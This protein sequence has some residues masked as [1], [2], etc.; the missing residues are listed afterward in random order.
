[1]ERCRC[2]GECAVAARAQAAPVPGPSLRWSARPPWGN[3]LRS[4]GDCFHGS[5]PDVSTAGPLPSVRDARKRYNDLAHKNITIDDPAFA[6]GF[7]A[8]GPVA[9]TALPEGVRS[10][11]I[12]RRMLAPDARVFLRI[13]DPELMQRWLKLARAGVG[14]PADL[15]WRAD[16]DPRHKPR[17]D[18]VPSTHEWGAGALTYLE[19][20]RVS[21]DL[22]GGGQLIIEAKAGTRVHCRKSTDRPYSPR[23]TEGRYRGHDEVF[24]DAGRADGLELPL[25]LKGNQYVPW[26]WVSCPTADSS[27]GCS[28][29]RSALRTEN[30]RLAT[31]S[32]P[33][34]HALKEVVWR[35]AIL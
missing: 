30:F 31:K 22:G 25:A 13:D 6:N 3:E 27:W 34:M 14:Q 24:F 7:S 20:T 12:D 1:M 9:G 21:V 32:V 4:K 5:S 33:D 17:D 18:E 23:L 19:A 15:P 11:V 16:R 8:F 35:T 29:R 28:G 10:L 26:R 2:R